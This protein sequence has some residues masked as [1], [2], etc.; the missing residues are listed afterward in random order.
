VAYL[1]AVL[2]DPRI[3]GVVLTGA[4]SLIARQPLHDIA[5][6]ALFVH[7]KED[8]CASFEAARQ[9]HPRLVNSPS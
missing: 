4:P 1:A 6:P 7:H 2:K 5:Y 9:Q 8:T 3:A